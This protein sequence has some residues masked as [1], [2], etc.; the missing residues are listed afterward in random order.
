MITKWGLSEKLGPMMF[1]EDE[2]EVFLGS[3]MSKHALEVSEDTAKI[4]DQEIKELIDRNYNRTKKILSDNID[5]L[6]AMA[7]AL[8]KFETIDKAQVQAIMDG[9]PLPERAS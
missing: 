9:Q 2:G 7:E 8:I 3:S 6:H 5:K 4:I 1:G